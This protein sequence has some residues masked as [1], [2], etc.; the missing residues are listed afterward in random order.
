MPN[1]GISEFAADSLAPTLYVE[2]KPFECTGWPDQCGQRSSDTVG[3]F[4]AR[5]G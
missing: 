5:L 4:S 2:S 3:Q 1:P